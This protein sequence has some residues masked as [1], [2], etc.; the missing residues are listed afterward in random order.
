MAKNINMSDQDLFN[1]AELFLK[2]NPSCEEALAQLNSGVEIKISL[3]KY[4][5][6]ALFYSDNKVQFEKRKA[7]NF[8]VEFVLYTEALRQFS[9]KSNLSVAEI[10]IEFLKQ[11]LLLSLIHI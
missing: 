11:V 2:N 10:G 3:D 7:K 9:N 8:D 5:D 6:A 4:C 1:L